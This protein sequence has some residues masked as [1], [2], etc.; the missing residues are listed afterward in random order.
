MAE[1]LRS[2]AARARDGRIIVQILRYEDGAHA[3]MAGM[4]S[5]MSFDDAPN[6]AY[7]ES[8]HSGQILDESE[9]VAAYWRSYDF[10]RAVALSPEASLTL[11]DSVAE[12]YA[13]AQQP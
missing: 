5:L 1:Q 13:N 8:V 6:L 7:T 9:P 11:L 4:V 3:M 12:E 10:A 2:I